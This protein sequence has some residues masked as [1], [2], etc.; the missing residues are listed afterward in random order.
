MVNA[1]MNSQTSSGR[2]PILAS[3]KL[4]RCLS[5]QVLF[6]SPST[7]TLYQSLSAVK[8]IQQVFVALLCFNWHAKLFSKR[9][10]AY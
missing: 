4:K 8:K 3:T 2:M 9:C 1:C 6:R 5:L 10:M 7:D